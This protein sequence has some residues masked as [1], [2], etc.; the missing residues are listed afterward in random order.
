VCTFR[1]KRLGWLS[2]PNERKPSQRN[3]TG[4]QPNLTQVDGGAWIN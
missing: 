3:E 2:L 1:G 4:A